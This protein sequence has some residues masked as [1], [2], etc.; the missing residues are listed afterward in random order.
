MGRPQKPDDERL[1][2]AK[3]NLTPAAF[4]YYDRIARERDIPLSVVL[5]ERLEFPERKNT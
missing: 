2:P 5:R 3:T 1:V 4:D